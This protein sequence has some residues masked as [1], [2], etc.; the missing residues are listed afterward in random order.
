MP[1]P[2]LA[3]IAI[4]VITGAIRKHQSNQ[5][6]QEL[7]DTDFDMPQSAY[8]ALDIH[9]SLAQMGLPGY[10]QIVDNIQGQLPETISQIKDA[11]STPSGVLGAV[12]QA[13]ENTLGQI[14]QVDIQDAIAKAQNQKELAN[15]MWG[16]G[17]AESDLEKLEKEYDVAGSR[18]RMAG[19]SSM[20]SSII[21]GA[22]SGISAYGA[23]KGS[24]YS[25]SDDGGGF[26]IEGYDFEQGGDVLDPNATASYY[27]GAYGGD[28]FY[29][30][31]EVF[32]DPSIDYNFKV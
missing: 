23:M 4:G 15:A 1:I 16:F 24:S 7:E 6:A 18:E 19:T 21:Q 12:T 31:G 10:E 3:G 9:K 30:S 5:L 22:S 28:S 17:L 27:Q 2:I 29:G 14:R 8:E 32:S 26:E 11:A 25:G 20:I 13:Q